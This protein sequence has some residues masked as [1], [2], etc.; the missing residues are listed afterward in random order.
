M[1]IRRRRMRDLLTL[2]G[3]I[4][5]LAAIVLINGYMR[6]EGLTAQYEKLRIALEE[7]IRGGGYTVIG[8]S[9]MHKVR[10]NRFTGPT[11]PPSLK[12]VD[13]KLVN[14]CGFM[15]PINQFRNVTEFMLLPVPI[16]CYF[17][18]APP[19][20][21]VIHVKLNKPANLVNEPVVIGGRLRLH[22]GAKQMFFYSIEDARWNEPVKGEE[23]T[24]KFV[25]QTHRTH[26]VEG[27]RQ[28]REGM[29]EEPLEKGFE[30]PAGSGQPAEPS[31]GD[32]A[33]ASPPSSSTP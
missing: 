4:A 6:R 9:E 29:P 22:E 12:E 15:S 20:R 19:M 17:C 25:D 27:F 1:A 32:S 24:E 7:K 14:I 28:L 8:W 5:V 33:G 18:D 16:T 10:G 13:G 21:D 3:I 31:S 30:P 26:L 23:T 11:F 2:A